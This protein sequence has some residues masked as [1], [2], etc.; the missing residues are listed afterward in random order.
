MSEQHVQANDNGEQAVE[1]VQSTTQQAQKPEK[2]DNLIPKHRFD[3]VNQQK[4]E[5]Q[6]ALKQVVDTMK[7]E[8]PENYQSLVPEMKPQDQIRW[9]QEARKAGLFEQKPAS[10]PE[11]ERP[12]SSSGNVD[13]QNLTPDQKFEL[14]MKQHKK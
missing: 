11:P 8:I 10:S 3:E 5:A 9:I 2:N 7:A 14:A 13:M 1:E 4:K 12:K 6:E